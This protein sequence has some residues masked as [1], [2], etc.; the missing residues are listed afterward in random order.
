MH[1]QRSIKINVIKIPVIEKS[2][3]KRILIKYKNKIKISK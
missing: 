3:K 2:Q 1:V